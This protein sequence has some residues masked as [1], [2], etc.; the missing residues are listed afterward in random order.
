MRKIKEYEEQEL[1]EESLS[2]IKELDIIQK[3]IMQFTVSERR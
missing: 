2:L 3:Q 1:F